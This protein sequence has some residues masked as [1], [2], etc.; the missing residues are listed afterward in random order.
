[1]NAYILAGVAKSAL[2]EAEDYRARYIEAMKK[3]GGVDDFEPSR[4]GLDLLWDTLREEE[5]IK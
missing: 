2:K 1:M 3:Y 5:E 4:I